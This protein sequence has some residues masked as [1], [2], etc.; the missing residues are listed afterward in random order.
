MNGGTEIGGS[1]KEV[2]FF[3]TVITSLGVV[4]SAVVALFKRHRHSVEFESK[5]NAH[6]VEAEQLIPQFHDLKEAVRANNEQIAALHE[7]VRELTA[8]QRQVLSALLRN[9][10]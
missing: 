1:W 2:G 9:A 3:A 10:G 5:V 4:G 7:D 6:L 8:M